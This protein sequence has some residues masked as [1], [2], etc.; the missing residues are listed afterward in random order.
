[1]KHNILFILPLLTLAAAPCYGQGC[2]GVHIA[3]ESITIENVRVKSMG[4][5]VTLAMT[6]NLDKLKMGA[7]NQFVFTPTITTDDGEVVMP[8]MVISGKR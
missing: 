3:N 7:N 1:M 8:K 4:K 6:V 5:R 2:N